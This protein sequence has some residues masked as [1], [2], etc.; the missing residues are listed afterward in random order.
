MSLKSGLVLLGLRITR[1]SGESDYEDL[2]RDLRLYFDYL[3]KK[4]Y[5]AET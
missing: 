3:I 1:T 2:S 4:K 5:K